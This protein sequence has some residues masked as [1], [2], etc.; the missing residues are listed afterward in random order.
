MALKRYE[1][2]A[3]LSCHLA[4]FLQDTQAASLARKKKIVGATFLLA[5][6]TAFQL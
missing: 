4:H 5:P 2:N 1:R 3:H 6:W